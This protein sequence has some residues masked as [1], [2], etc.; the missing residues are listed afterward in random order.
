M[1]QSSYLQ[2]RH[3]QELSSGRASIVVI[4]DNHTDVFLIKEALA[5][6]RLD[7]EL[8]VVDDGEEGINLIARLDLDGAPL[9]RLILLDLN[10][11]KAD[12]FAVLEHLRRSKRAVDIPVLVMTSSPAEADRVKSTALKANA[13]F[14]KPTSYDAFL[15]IGEIIQRLLTER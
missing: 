9:P 3:E 2:S 4:E 11:P 6:R 10:L 1:D 15:Q 12:G 8:T 13:Y 7:V 5:A 14:Q